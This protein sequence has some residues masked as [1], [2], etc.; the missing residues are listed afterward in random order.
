[1]SDALFLGILT[2]AKIATVSFLTFWGLT[3]VINVFKNLIK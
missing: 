2:G 3:E 1:M